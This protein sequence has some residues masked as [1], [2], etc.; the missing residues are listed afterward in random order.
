M[1]IFAVQTFLDLPGERWPSHDLMT[2]VLGEP[3]LTFTDDV[4][5]P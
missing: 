3:R 1:Q 5:Y 4:P 2:A